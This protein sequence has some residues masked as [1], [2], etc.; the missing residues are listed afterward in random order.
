VTDP[1]RPSTADVVV[2]G[3]GIV[4]LAT[5]RAALAA[6]PGA[7]VVVVEKE[8]AVAR[9]QTGR[10]SGVIH[11]GIY[12][13]PGSAK[14]RL[15]A[16]G[17]VLLEQFCDDHGIAFD[18]CGKVIV[19]T[20]Q[21]ELGRL[22]RLEDQARSHGLA[23]RRLDRAG[24]AQV[25]PHAAGLA[26]LAVPET[27]IVDYTDVA[28]ALADDLADRGAQIRT[29]TTVTGLRPLVPRTGRVIPPVGWSIPPSSAGGV[30]VDTDQG[31]ISARRVVNCAGLFSDRIADLDRPDGPTD[32]DA[33]R[34]TPFRGEFHDLVP[35]AQHLVRGLIYPVPDPAFPF[36][37]VHLTR[38]IHGGV[39]AGPNA[40]LALAREGYRWTDVSMV[41]VAEMARN[42]AMWRLARRHWRT[43]GA[44]VWRSLSTGA[45]VRALQR[46]V[47]ELTAAD[48]E[49]AP[50]GV[51]AQALRRDGTL[52]DDFAF[53]HRGPVL[54]VLNAPSPAA[55][56]SLAIG[57]EIIA[58]LGAN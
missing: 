29:S 7:H 11:S 31:S 41:D 24:L 13:R 4:G 42:P 16:R 50:S 10:N 49:P 57:E 23:V 27:A 15:V 21:N 19:A 28:A 34:I 47:P 35:S 14:A 26:A 46:L 2:I 20:S 54:H 58:R 9:H 55:T 44:E 56:A 8:S 43:G 32:I 12:Y 18:R 52:V 36:L 48:I 1:T 5:A 51:R 38:S 53:Q 37:G 25:E 33:V 45:L 17:R 6:Q 3:G 30:V 40:V 39:H 22:A